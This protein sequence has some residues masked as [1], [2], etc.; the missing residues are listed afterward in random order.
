MPHEY[1]REMEG[2][3]EGYRQW[4]QKHFFAT[5][6]DM[7]VDDVILANL[8]PE[9]CHFLP[10]EA[11]NAAAPPTKRR[12]V[13]CS[14]VIEK[15]PVRGFVFARNMDW[16]SLRMA[17]SHSL[18]VRRKHSNGL[19][20][21]IEVG[22]PGIIGT[23]TGMNSK[24]LSLAMNVCSGETTEVQGLPSTLYNRLCLERC[25]SVEAL[26]RFSQVNDP[27]GPYHLSAADR[28]EACSLHFFQSPLKTHVTR[29]C[30]ENKP[31]VTL[32]CRYA[33]RPSAPMNESRER[34]KV[35][36]QFFHNRRG[37]PLEDVLSLRP[38]DCEM[39]IHRIVMEPKSCTMRVAFDN[40]YAGSRPLHLVKW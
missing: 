30:A 40:A 17:G 18:V 5:R 16:P 15:D 21:T 8:L 12:R 6:L 23:I 28:H 3:V 22:L 13:A 2:L 34:Q 33:P 20:D 9:M 29:Q 1:L 31:L 7:S 19:L 36:N 32:N 25:E 10:K 24:G 38:V 26:K 11:E 4:A 27:L 35:I 14:A 39:T 37:R